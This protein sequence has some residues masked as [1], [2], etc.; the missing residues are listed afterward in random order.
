M[1]C[2]AEQKKTNLSKLYIFLEQ[3]GREEIPVLHLSYFYT[4]DDLNNG[5]VR[6]KTYIMSQIKY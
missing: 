1:D 2:N 4:A 5:E 6:I 3:F